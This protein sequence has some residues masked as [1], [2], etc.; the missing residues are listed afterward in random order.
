[1]SALSTNP[2]S[3]KALFVSFPFYNLYHRV[4]SS[5]E[6][7]H[8]LF[9]F[10]FYYTNSAFSPALAPSPQRGAG[11]GGPS[12]RRG[13]SD[14]LRLR[15]LPP[16]PGPA[17]RHPRGAAGQHGPARHRHGPRA[18]LRA[19]EEEIHSADEQA[20]A[21]AQGEEAARV[22]GGA[23]EH[24]PP[25]A[26]LPRGTA[27]PGKRLLLVWSRVCVDRTGRRRDGI[28]GSWAGFGRPPGWQGC[29]GACR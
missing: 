12:R 10:R 19:L 5:A 26:A 20:A 4:F 11:R 14:A 23:G 27:G 24:R 9:C 29:W 18:Q 3:M 1:M 16:R 6:L 28:C 25:G 17:E 21:A 7:R 2:S 8:K 15:P 13:P 22:A